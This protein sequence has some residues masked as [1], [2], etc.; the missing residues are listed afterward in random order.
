MENEIKELLEMLRSKF[1][2]ESF[3]IGFDYWGHECDNSFEF[4][5]NLSRLPGGVDPTIVSF[6]N[7]KNLKNAV[8][9]V[10]SERS[11]N[12]IDKQI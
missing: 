5:F 12:E 10:C 2:K 11:K 3:H 4:T 9:F 1:P 8:K 7:L 6:S